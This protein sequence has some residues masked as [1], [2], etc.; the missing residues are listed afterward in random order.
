MHLEGLHDGQA[1]KGEVWKEIARED[2]MVGA[3]R[4]SR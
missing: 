3:G 4:K 2:R 1:K